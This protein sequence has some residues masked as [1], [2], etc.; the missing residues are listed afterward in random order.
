MPPVTAFKWATG[1]TIAASGILD[2]MLATLALQNRCVPGIANLQELA[3][4]CANLNVQAASRS[5][6]ENGHALVI[7]RGFA[8]MNAC[9][10]LKGCA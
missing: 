10:M 5:L 6:A 3:P 7:N 9:I 4:S 1:H 2:T 8:G